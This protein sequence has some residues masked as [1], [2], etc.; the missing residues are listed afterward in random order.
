MGARCN[1]VFKQSED[2]AVCLYSHWDEDNMDYVLA[3]ALQHARPR[4]QMGDIPYATR[5]AISYIIKDQILDETGYGIT[6]M[7]PSDQGFLDHPITIDLT[8]MTVGS[9]EDWH[10]IEDFINYQLSSLTSSAKVG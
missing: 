9:G 7:D 5:M 10:T 2:M 1:F 3:Q 4:L 6:A 8:D